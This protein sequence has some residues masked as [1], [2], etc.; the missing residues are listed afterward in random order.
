MECDVARRTSHFVRRGDGDGI[1]EGPMAAEGPD[2]VEMLGRASPSPSSPPLPTSLAPDDDARAR[3][4]EKADAL[5]EILRVVAEATDAL[6]EG[7]LAKNR[8]LAAK[9]RLRG[10]KQRMLDPCDTRSIPE[11]VPSSDRDEDDASSRRRAP[12]ERVE[13]TTL[14]AAELRRSRAV[15][16]ACEETVS[17]WVGLERDENTATRLLHAALC[18]ALRGSK[19]IQFD[20]ARALAARYANA[21]GAV[22][23]SLSPS[24]MHAAANAMIQFQSS[25]SFGAGFVTGL[26][27]LLTLPVTLPANVAANMVTNLRL[28]FAV[29]VLGGHDPMRPSVAAAAINAA[30]GLT[31]ETRSSVAGI[32][33]GHADAVAAH[34]VASA[35]A[36]DES[37]EDGSEAARTRAETTEAESVSKKKIDRERSKRLIDRSSRTAPP[38]PRSA[39]TAPCCKARRGRWRAA[40]PRAWPLRA[41]REPAARRARRFRFSAGSSAAADA[42]AACRGAGRRAGS[43][44]RS[45]LWTST[46]RAPRRSRLSFRS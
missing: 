11:S 2:A 1:E 39:A 22:G 9:F 33:G 19:D 26:G 44:P 4:L 34:D 25:L 36:A 43:C 17:F 10:A 27:G 20:G 37:D 7:A 31:E 45:R 41:R 46:D 14:F 23:E 42:A 28:V 15:A 8:V 40:L 12:A 38:A 16:D 6:P 13:K 18:V 30:L 5:S 35:A 29:A 21:N 32:R 24:R 3:L